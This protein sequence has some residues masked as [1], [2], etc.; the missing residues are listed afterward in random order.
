MWEWPGDEASINHTSGLLI[1]FLFFPQKY[2]VDLAFWGHHHTYQ[3][4]CPI[5]NNQCTDGATTHVIIG[6]AGRSLLHNLRCVID[7]E[8][9]H[10]HLQLGQDLLFLIISVCVC[11]C[12]CVF[13]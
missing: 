9:T 5:V 11:V 3:R 2:K 13:L 12:V 6:M 1:L 4:M 7:R 10:S 8:V